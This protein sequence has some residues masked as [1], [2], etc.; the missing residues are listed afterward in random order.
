EAKKGK[1]ATIG[2]IVAFVAARPPDLEASIEP[3]GPFFRYPVLL[4][5]GETLTLRDELTGAL[6]RAWPRDLAAG[7]VTVILR[8]SGTAKL[9]LPRL[10]LT[11]AEVIRAFK[12]DKPTVTLELQ[13]GEA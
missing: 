10:S 6:R 13:P 12:D 9:F 4:G 3:E 5:P 7:S 11:T 2:D 8:S 1:K